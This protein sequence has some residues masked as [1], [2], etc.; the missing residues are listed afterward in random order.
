MSRYSPTL[1]TPP[2]EEEEIYPYRRVWTS[3]IIENGILFGA[4]IVFFVV[5]NILGINFPSVI[6]APL[7]LT[8][9]LLPAILWLIFSYYRERFALEPRRN[10]LLVFVVSA[11]SANAIGIP[12]VDQF[13]DVEEWLSLS[14]ATDRILGYTFTIGVVQ[15]TIKY[16][17]I[18]Y[19]AW[20]DG[21]RIRRDA[22]AYAAA[23][24][25]GY[26]TVLNLYFI[27]DGSPPP[28]LVIFRIIS[29]I[30]IHTSASIIISYGL[31][32]LRFNPSTPVLMPFTLL[33]ST[34]ITGIAIPFRA[35]LVNA[36]FFL[37]IAQTNV[38]FGIIFSAGL[39]VA[40]LFAI[41]FLYENAER[42]QREAEI[43]AEIRGSA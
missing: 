10:L 23:S 4:A 24:A 12:L 21:F 18:R 3:V 8:L 34:L 28:N 41:A 29:T 38:L 32:E 15:E 16:I 27:A 31:A 40:P 20:E 33:V 9:G 1:L 7:N 17:I 25:V 22:I 5:Y 36:G 37:G 11:L 39:L 6:T 13:L 14:S 35:G 19:I 42:R 43:E 2:R 30:A 26:A